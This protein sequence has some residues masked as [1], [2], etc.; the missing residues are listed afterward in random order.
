MTTPCVLVAFGSKNGG[1]AEIAEWIGDT[2]REAG[3]NVEVRPA[4]AVGDLHSYTAVVL[5]SG[6]YGDR[7]LPD[8]AHF[9][10]RHREALRGVPVWLFSSGP[11]DTSADE[12]P[13]PAVRTAARLAG[14]LGA[15]EHVTFG[16]RLVPGAHGLV[17]R[18]I[19]RRG[20]SGDFR[21]KERVRAWARGI[22]AQ[23]AG[24][25]APM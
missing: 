4:P 3:L 20:G 16:G 11:L 2:L 17:A 14:D 23:V 22:A 13:L 5:G 25:P 10:R 7:W 15:R 12:R 9:A 19:L 21:D 18:M 6:V 24:A 1:T 8:A